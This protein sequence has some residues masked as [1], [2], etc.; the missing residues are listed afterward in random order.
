MRNDSSKKIIYRTPHT[1][2]FI[3][4]QFEEECHCANFVSVKPK[5]GKDMIYLTFLKCDCYMSLKSVA[6]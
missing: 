3:A 5:H 6:N 1:T 2:V 4:R